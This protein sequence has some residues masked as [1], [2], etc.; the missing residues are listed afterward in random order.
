MS[1]SQ[2]Q[3]VQRLRLRTLPAEQ[4]PSDV[5]LRLHGR[6]PLRRQVVR[7]TPLPVVRPV[8]LLRVAHP[9]PLHV[10]P[11]LLRVS[12]KVLREVEGEYPFLL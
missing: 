5:K 3:P 2:E 10:R 4:L 8:P 1:T 12:A 9:A 11:A 6:L 7:R